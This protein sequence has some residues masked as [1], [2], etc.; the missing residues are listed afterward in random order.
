M[1]KNKKPWYIWF[2][3]VAFMLLWSN[4]TRQ[5]KYEKSKRHMWPRACWNGLKLWG[6]Y[7]MFIPISSLVLL[8]R[9][10]TFITHMISVNLNLEIVAT[11]LS[12]YVLLAIYLGGVYATYKHY[13]WRK[14]NNLTKEDSP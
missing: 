12:L 5:I 3:A 6:T 11:I 2:S 1:S 8:G 4:T 9:L 7:V 14:E 10:A 13:I